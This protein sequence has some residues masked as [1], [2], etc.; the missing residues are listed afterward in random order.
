MARKGPWDV[1]VKTGPHERE[2]VTG[3]RVNLIKPCPGDLV[4]FD[5]KTLDEGS[6]S[7]PEGLSKVTIIEVHH[8]GWFQGHFIVVEKFR[9]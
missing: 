3:L 5:D 8:H 6:S 1:Y 4:N 2:Q 9:G 7:P